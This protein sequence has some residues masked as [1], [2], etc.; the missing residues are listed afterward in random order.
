MQ[1]E[2]MQKR[3][4]D[5]ADAHSAQSYNPR[6]PVAGNTLA[7]RSLTISSPGMWRSEIGPNVAARLS[8]GFG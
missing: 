5:L 8:L 3:H 4:P 7:F 6:R 1:L 2:L